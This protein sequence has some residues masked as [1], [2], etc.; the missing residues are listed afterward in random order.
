MVGIVQ[1]KGCQRYYNADVDCYLRMPTDPPP[2]DH[3]VEMLFELYDE[4]D[5]ILESAC[6]M[7]DNQLPL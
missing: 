4:E 2:V 5:A 3:K 1:P 7:I 6:P